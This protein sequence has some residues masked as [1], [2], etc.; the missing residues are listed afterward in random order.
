M[1][2]SSARILAAASSSRQG[3]DIDPFVEGFLQPRRAWRYCRCGHC[4]GRSSRTVS[5][6][7]LSVEA[8]HQ[9]GGDLFAEF[10]GN[11]THPDLLRDLC[12]LRLWA[13]RGAPGSP[14]ICAAAQMREQAECPRAFP[15]WPERRKAARARSPARTRRS[16]S[17]LRSARSRQSAPYMRVC[18]TSPRAVRI[19]R[20][21]SKPA[22]D[23]RPCRP[24][25][26]T[27]SNRHSRG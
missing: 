15:Q 7:W 12:A 24:R 13:W 18:G 26:A 22:F 10:A 25:T 9:D 19:V 8:R 3:A 4:P 6:S 21:A 1:S 20:L 16:K 23:I 14:D 2:I 27:G 5:R 17:A 11:I